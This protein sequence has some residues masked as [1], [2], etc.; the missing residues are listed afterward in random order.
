MAMTKGDEKAL[1]WAPR[2]GLFEG[3]RIP[4]M[5][6]PCY[7]REKK[8]RFRYLYKESRE[9]ITYED[10]EEQNTGVDLLD[11]AGDVPPWVFGLTSGNGDD[12][13]SN[14]GESSLSHDVP[15]S[16]MYRVSALVLEV[17]KSRAHQGS[18]Q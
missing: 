18:A 6:V 11:G 12:L 15:P 9:R 7:S 17:D 10:I 3:T 8:I 4:I 14:E 13:S 16:F 1:D 2:S 5:N